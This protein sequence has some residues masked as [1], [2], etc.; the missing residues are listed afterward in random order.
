MEIDKNDIHRIVVTYEGDPSLNLVYAEVGEDVEIFGAFSG[1]CGG[2]GM[3]H[4][5]SDGE[6]SVSDDPFEFDTK[7]MYVLL[8][9]SLC[10]W[11]WF[12]FWFLLLLLIWLFNFLCP[13]RW[14]NS[15]EIKNLPIGII[16]SRYFFEFIYAILL[17]CSACRIVHWM[18]RDKFSIHQFLINNDF[19]F[20]L[21]I[22]DHREIVDCSLYAS[23]VF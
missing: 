21:D 14:N 8:R 15:G 1:I 10:L 3:F 20:F 23:K 16:S 4:Q 6:I 7:F 11:R 19:D 5:N 17:Y 9:F 13:S 22:V 12:R 18:E 2:L